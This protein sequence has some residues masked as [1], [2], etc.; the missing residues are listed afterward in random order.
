LI[1]HL[2]AESISQKA[3]KLFGGLSVYYGRSNLDKTELI[4]LV[5][6]AS[7]GDK[8]SFEKLYLAKSKSILFSALSIVK[9]YHL[10]E[11]AAQEVVVAM[12]RHIGKLRDPAAF[13]AWMQRIV[14]NECYR[15]LSKISG[16]M[17]DFDDD[18]PQDI[19]DDDRDFL[20][21]K[22]AEDKELG[23]RLFAAIEQL[24]R[25]KRQAITLYYY[26]NLS[27]EEIAYAMDSSIKSVS[28][29][30][31]R[32]RQMIREMLEKENNESAGLLAAAPTSVLGSVIGEHASILIPDEKI[33]IFQ[34]K[35]AV[36][37]KPI[38]Y[39]VKAQ[40][41]SGAKMAA[42]VI[43]GTAAVVAILFGAFDLGDVNLSQG[44]SLSVAPEVATQTIGESGRIDFAG[45][46][47]ECGHIN[48]HGA[49][50]SEMDIEY[51]TIAWEIAGANGEA[52]ISGE[53]FATVDG[54]FAKMQGE[55]SAGRY[56]LRYTFTDAENNTL[57]VERAF[58]IA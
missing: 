21:E 53:G 30:I 7:R 55:G 2:A 11:D 47:C 33:V 36:T 52:L 24:P 4:A 18:E 28:S 40:I 54:A 38:M 17:E 1:Q 12:Y 44:V 5:R 39:S 56:V 26:N 42:L 48:P 32:A 58:E 27:Y 20:P 29:N 16:R 22:Y 14:T 15:L 8:T 19:A 31:T 25:K 34:Q 35:C 9:D 45:G 41:A 13:E 37:L 3:G 51:K 46:D 43:A 10:A 57:V 6:K 23:N 49:S 50:V